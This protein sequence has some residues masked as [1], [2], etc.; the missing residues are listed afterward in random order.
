VRR[1]VRRACDRHRLTAD[2]A[3][4]HIGRERLLD[5]LAG[6]YRSAVGLQRMYLMDICALLLQW[7]R[8]RVLPEHS[9]HD[10]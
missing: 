9:A 5:S 4:W 6:R 7:G 8:A 10:P 1:A 3:L 2:A